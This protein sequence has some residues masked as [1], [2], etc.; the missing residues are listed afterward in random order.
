MAARTIGTTTAAAILLASLDECAG[1][2]LGLLAVGSGD[3]RGSLGE[4]IVERD[5]TASAERI[6]EGVNDCVLDI[7][8]VDSA[9]ALGAEEAVGDWEV[10]V[11]DCGGVT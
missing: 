7:L 8:V 10:V 4:A 6:E 9:S 1:D 11:A 2:G 3:V 5:V